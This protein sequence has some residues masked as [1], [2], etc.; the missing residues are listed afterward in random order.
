MQTAPTPQPVLR[1]F[2][3]SFGRNTIEGQ[4]IDAF[5]LTYEQP[6]ARVDRDPFSAD[7][8]HAFVIHGI[9]TEVQQTCQAEQGACGQTDFC[10]PLFHSG[11]S[12]FLDSVHG[13]N[14]DLRIAAL[15]CKQPDGSFEIAA[16][17]FGKFLPPE[18][19]FF[20]KT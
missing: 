6:A 20:I 18:T 3:T 14:I 16:H 11:A 15:L 10:N 19:Q 17:L 1:S 12:I 2:E 4:R 9:L 13:L 5:L 7:G 8:L